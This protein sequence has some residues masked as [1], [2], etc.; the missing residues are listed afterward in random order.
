MKCNFI[1]FEFTIFLLKELKKIGI[2]EF[3]LDQ[4]ETD[5]YSYINKYESIFTYIK[6]D[7]NRVLLREAINI[8]IS[9][10]YVC[11][12]TLNKKVVHILNIDINII[13]KVYDIDKVKAIKKLVNEYY[14]DKY[15]NMKLFEGNPNGLYL[16]LNSFNYEESVNWSLV[17]DASKF[18][19]YSFSSIKDNMCVKSPFNSSSISTIRNGNMAKVLISGKSSFVLA[20]QKINGVIK[21]V[22]LYIDSTN[23]YSKEKLNNYIL[24]ET[25]NNLDIKVLKLSK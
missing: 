10:G 2:N 24:L 5:L 22:N 17:T 16:I 13:G 19:I 4:L 12:P 18:N 9:C 1:N 20:R 7:K 11:I 25:P 14:V 15:I 8:L 3:N 23:N 6:C 21:D